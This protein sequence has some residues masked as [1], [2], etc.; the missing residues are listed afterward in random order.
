MALFNKPIEWLRSGLGSPMRMMGL[1]IMQLTIGA[2]LLLWEN[3]KGIFYFFIGFA[4][5]SMYYYAAFRLLQAHDST[6][7]VGKKQNSVFDVLCLLIYL[8][9]AASVL[10]WLRIE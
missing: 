2:N 3:P 1:V 6:L 8:A 5:P 4:I 7:N 9:V 10:Y